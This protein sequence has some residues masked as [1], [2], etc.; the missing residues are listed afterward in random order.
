MFIE[1]EYPHKAKE[2]I[3]AGR[4]KPAG[5]D[6]NIPGVNCLGDG[7]VARMGIIA[8]YEDRVTAHSG[9]RNRATVMKLPKKAFISQTMI[10]WGESRDEAEAIWRSKIV[11]AGMQPEMVGADLVPILFSQPNAIEGTWG[12]DIER[13][14]GGHKHKLTDAA[15]VQKVMD[16]MSAGHAVAE[17]GTQFKDMGGD[18]FANLLLDTAPSSASLQFTQEQLKLT[19]IDPKTL[20]KNVQPDVPMPE[21]EVLPRDDGAPVLITVPMS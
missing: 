2:A 18:L 6:P 9:V 15:E 13:S 4:V 8:I 7:A 17:L 11:A 10:F 19:M 1:K 16:G 5:E 21:A 12:R 20:P 14:V 3:R